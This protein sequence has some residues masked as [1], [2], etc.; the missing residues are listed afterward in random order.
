MSLW[1]ER[2]EQHRRLSAAAAEKYDEIYESANF[3]TGSYMQFEIDKIRELVGQAS[4]NDLAV[5]LGCGT[6]RTTFELAKTFRQVY[7]CD[8]SP[9]MI[10]VATAK[11]HQKMTGNV[12]FEVRDV[13]QLQVPLRDSTVSFINTGFGMGS[14]IQDLGSLFR[15]I[16]RLLEPGGLA[17]FS[18]YSSEALVNSLDLEWKPALAARLAADK[19]SLKVDFEG[20]VYEIA[21]RAYTLG[22]IRRQLDGNFKVVDITTFPTLSALFP[23]SLFSDKRARNL[24]SLVDKLLS[25][26]SEL[27]AG[28]YIVAAGRKAGRPKRFEPSRGYARVLELLSFYKIKVD[29]KIHKPVRT[30][31]D[32]QLVLGVPPEEMV[33]SVLVA[34]DSSDVPTPTSLNARLYLCCVPANMKLDMGKVGRYLKLPRSRIRM[35]TQIEVEE[36]TGFSVGSIPPFGMPD[37]VPIIVDSKILNMQSVWCGTGKPTESLRLRVNQL[38]RLSACAEADLTKPK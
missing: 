29:P 3:A 20:T 11:K 7:A 8:L 12:S 22:E 10:E 19:N 25:T 13:E 36:L 4:S 34:A 32:V 35:A 33:K 16:R 23:Q 26:N 15:E 6:G 2:K 30:M 27:A 21:A 28:P 31:Q 14:F 18:F 1:E 38:K 9:E 5:D 17:V 37:S 24:C